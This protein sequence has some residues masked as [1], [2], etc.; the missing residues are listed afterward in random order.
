MCVWPPLLLFRISTSTTTHATHFDGPTIIYESVM[1]MGQLAITTHTSIRPSRARIDCISLKY[2]QG[3]FRNPFP[4]CNEW[5]LR[6]ASYKVNWFQT[7]ALPELHIHTHTGRKCTSHE[8]K[9]NQNAVA[10]GI[11]TVSMNEA[12]EFLRAN[13]NVKHRLILDAKNVG[14]VACRK[15]QQQRRRRQQAG[16]REK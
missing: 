16:W 3:G 7:T 10:A 6:A 12:E 9:I 15:R 2:R 14:F 13:S 5:H 4:L 8:E 1:V 11:M